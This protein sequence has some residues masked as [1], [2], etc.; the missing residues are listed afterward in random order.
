MIYAKNKEGEFIYPAENKK[1]YCPSCNTE[2]FPN[3]KNDEYIHWN[4]PYD[5]NCKF[6]TVEVGPKNPRPVISITTKLL[7]DND[8]W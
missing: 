5:S 1:G 8:W 7:N 6:Y 2:V 3:L 4:H